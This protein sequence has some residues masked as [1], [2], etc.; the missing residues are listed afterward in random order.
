MKRQQA[1]PLDLNALRADLA[2]ANEIPLYSI[3]DDA[4]FTLDQQL[5]FQRLT[6]A[7]PALLAIAGGV[8][9]AL[10]AGA[11]LVVSPAARDV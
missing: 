1:K 11:L 4:P 3:P 10:A 5:A 8:G 9:A 2:L 7:V 6:A